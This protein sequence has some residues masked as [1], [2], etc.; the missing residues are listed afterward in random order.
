DWSSRALLRAE[1]WLQATGCAP[2]G[3]NV[4]QL[5]LLDARY[6]THYWNGAPVRPGKNFGWSDWLY[7]S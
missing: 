3:D 5:P 4:W 7:G 1:Q 2:S 6:G